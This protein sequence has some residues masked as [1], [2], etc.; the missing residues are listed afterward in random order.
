[1]SKKI[2]LVN[3]KDKGLSKDNY[4]YSYWLI[5]SRKNRKRTENDQK[6][7]LKKEK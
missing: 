2:K 3:Q 5:Y 4:C 6:R 7:H 1:M